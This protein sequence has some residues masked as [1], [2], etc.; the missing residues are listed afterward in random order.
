MQALV[1]T[2]KMKIILQTMKVKVTSR[3]KFHRLNQPRSVS[4][5]HY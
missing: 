1:N 5:A 3:T 4:N 2:L